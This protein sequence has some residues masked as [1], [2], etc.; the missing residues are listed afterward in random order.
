MRIGLFFT[1]QGPRRTPVMVRL[2]RQDIDIAP[3]V[4]DY[5]VEDTYRIPVEALP[6]AIQPHAHYRAREVT[7]S[8]GLADGRVK[9]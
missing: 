9:P 3:G 4:S 6:P 7:A 2:A 1:D 8:V 5:P